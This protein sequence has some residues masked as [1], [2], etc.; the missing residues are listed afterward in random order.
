MSPSGIT[1]DASSNSTCSF[2]RRYF[3]ADAAFTKPEVYE[4]LEEQRVLYTIRIASD[5]VLEKEIQHLPRRPVGRPPKKPNIWHDDFQYRAGHWVRTG[6]LG[7]LSPG[8]EA[9][10]LGVGSAEVA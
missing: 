2:R 5:G 3:R 6:R 9:R 10:W 8:L 7:L 4:Y 1:S